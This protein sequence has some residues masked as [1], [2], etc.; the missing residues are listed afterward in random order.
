MSLETAVEFCSGLSLETEV[1][2]V[3]NCPERMHAA[4]AAVLRNKGFV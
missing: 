1:A 3:D 2:A 4:E